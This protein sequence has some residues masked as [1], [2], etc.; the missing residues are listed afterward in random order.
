MSEIMT[1]SCPVS[2]VSTDSV[3]GAEC[4]FVN[5]YNLTLSPSSPPCDSLVI[6][7]PSYIAKLSYPPFYLYIC[8]NNTP[9]YIPRKIMKSFPTVIINPK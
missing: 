9:E 1:I 5:K 2:R 8:D 7:P 3:V 4:N 6:V